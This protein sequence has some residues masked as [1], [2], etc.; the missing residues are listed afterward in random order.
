MAA[1]A[2]PVI[3]V[4]GT[5]VA[6]AAGVAVRG[7]LD[8]STAPLLDESLDAAIRD[9]AGT[10]VVD[11]TR[12]TFVDSTGV[13]VLL[14]ARALLGRTDREIVVVCPPGQVRRVLELVGV[15][16][17]FAIYDTREEA[18]AALG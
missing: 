16:D 10:F 1:D 7:E 11:V 9:S 15:D 2:L 3:E 18:A 14:R 17:L 4:R 8:M 5:S 6:G 12:V 13:N